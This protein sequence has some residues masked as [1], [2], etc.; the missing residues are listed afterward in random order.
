MLLLA[1]RPF[2]DSIAWT[3]NRSCLIHEVACD[4]LSPAFPILSPTSLP[5]LW[6]FSPTKTKVQALITGC[7][8]TTLFLC[9]V[10]SS[11][12]MPFTHSCC[13]QGCLV[14]NAWH[15]MGNLPRHDSS[16][17]TRLYSVSDA[18]SCSPL[19]E[20]WDISTVPLPVYTAKSSGFRVCLYTSN[21]QAGAWHVVHIQCFLL[22]GTSR[23]VP[24]PSGLPHT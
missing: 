8:S 4:P 6:S 22:K 18:P 17:T 11:V 7:R 3:Q 20:Y 14:F 23:Q 1:F 21:S 12:G 13:K 9:T 2:A 15:T 5:P 10:L 24:L 19:T 16:M